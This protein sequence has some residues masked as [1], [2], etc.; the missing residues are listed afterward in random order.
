MEEITPLLLERCQHLI[1]FD[2]QNEETFEFIYQILQKLFSLKNSPYILSAFTSELLTYLIENSDNKQHIFSSNEIQRLKSKYEKTTTDLVKFYGVNNTTEISQDFITYF[3]DK[4]IGEL[5]F[6][7]DLTNLDDKLSIY[8]GVCDLTWER[9]IA[10]WSITGKLQFIQGDIVGSL[11][12]IDPDLLILHNND[13][14]KHLRDIL[15]YKWC[16][17]TTINQWQ[18]I[19]DKC[20]STLQDIEFDNSLNKSDNLIDNNL[21]NSKN[22]NNNNNI[23]NKDLTLSKV[24]SKSYWE[25]KWWL[26]FAMFL[27]GNYNDVIIKFNELITTEKFTSKILGNS[28]EGLKNLDSTVIDSKSILRIVIICA[29]LTQNNKKRDILWQNSLLVDTFFEDSLIK[30]FKESYESI[31]YPKVKDILIQINNEMLWCRQLNVTF[32]K[33]KSLLFQKSMISYLSFVNSITLDQL[34]LKFSAEKSII[35][36]YLIRSISILNLPLFFD[37]KREILEY[38]YDIERFEIDLTKNTHDNVDEE[39]LR[40]K[41]LKLNNILV[42]GD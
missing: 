42:H 23:E 29:I 19:L 16:D 20:N 18:Y 31:N 36:D 35:K 21:N 13:K 38:K 33:V 27:A 8:K 17:N 11:Y 24:E 3:Y 9:D 10:L 2:P 15:A 30:E 39:I 22:G 26:L 40:M 1:L 37:D 14:L 12:S 5:S 28:I 4:V 41:A 25:I 6:N 7:K 32:E 34:A